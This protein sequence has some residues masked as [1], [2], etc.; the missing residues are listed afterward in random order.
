MYQRNA[1][2]SINESNV[3]KR[4]PLSTGSSAAAVGAGGASGG[5]GGAATATALPVSRV[6]PGPPGCELLVVTGCPSSSS[7]TRSRHGDDNKTVRKMRYWRVWLA[8]TPVE[9]GLGEQGEHLAR[10]AAQGDVDDLTQCRELGVDLDQRH[11]SAG[12]E[13]REHRCGIDHR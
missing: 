13:L 7:A 4:R 10:R 12:G 3:L 11:A 5:R 6:V 2:T 1:G 8:R 9:D